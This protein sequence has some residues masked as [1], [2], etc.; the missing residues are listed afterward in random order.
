M[1][2]QQNWRVGTKERN[3]GEAQRAPRGGREK[4]RKGPTAGVHAA[5]ASI[6]KVGQDKLS[7]KCKFAE[8]TG[9]T[10]SHPPWLFKAFGDKTPE[11]RSRIIMDDKL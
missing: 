1:W 3:T 9:C 2:Q 5:T 10:G 7:R 6:E 8:L 4:D 11:E